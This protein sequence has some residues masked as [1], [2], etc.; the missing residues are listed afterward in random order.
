MKPIEMIIS[1]V[2]QVLE[3]GNLAQVF[4]LDTNDLASALLRR[5]HDDGVTD[6]PGL[7]GWIDDFLGRAGIC[8]ALKS[9]QLEY[10]DNESKESLLKKWFAHR[11]VDE[12]PQPRARPNELAVNLTEMAYQVA[13]TPGS[14]DALRLMK[15]PLISLLRYTSLFYA[16]EF[17]RNGCP[18]LREGDGK[19]IADK[20]GELTI[21]ELCELLSYDV[22]VRAKPYD[23]TSRQKF[24]L[25]DK[26]ACTSLSRLAD[27]A[28]AESAWSPEQSKEFSA[29]LLAVLQAWRGEDPYTPKACTVAEI[30]ETSFESRLTCYDEIG[31]AVILSGVGATLAYGSDVLVRAAD[32]GT[33]WAPEPQ[34]VP[35]TAAWETPE[36]GSRESRSTRTVKVARRDQVFISY[37]HDDVRWLKELQ[38]HLAP[39]TRNT[40]IE[41]WDDTKI[42]AGAV[43]R[44]SIKQALA[45]AKVAV[46]LVSPAFVASKRNFR[47]SWKQ[48]GPRA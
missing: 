12:L 38:K 41:V 45:S 32:E 5:L 17:R 16:D 34:M 21:D 35:G 26:T 44:D 11:G 42:K 30:L 9:L 15:A 13:A 39:Y 23:P 6:A 48:P 22:P 18:V 37:S 27:L 36:T 8:S 10:G 31:N 7:M 47:R 14:L 4:G 28:G 19:K 25:A 2:K 29:C 43:W 3:A 33:L 1:D 46:L 40:T 20:L 24:T